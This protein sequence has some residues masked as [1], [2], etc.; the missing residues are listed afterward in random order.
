MCMRMFFSEEIFMRRTIFHYF[1]KTQLILWGASLLLI[2]VC[3]V[4]FGGTGYLTLAASLIGATSLIFNAKGNPFGQLLSVVFSVLYGIISYSFH[5][6]GEMITYLGMTAPMALFSFVSWMRNPFCAGRAEV[7]V[8]HLRKKE[9]V[10]MLLVCAAVTWIFYYVLRAFHTANLGLSTLSV[11]TSFL[12][13][14]LTWRRSCFFA[15]A[16]AANDIILILLW[17][18]ASFTDPAYRSVIV[19]FILFL[20]N[21]LYGF[22]CWRRMQKRQSGSADR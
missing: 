8:H 19:C 14:F 3:F 6:Y 7:R 22:F 2:S 11:S 15:L 17:I 18:L 5:Y 10:L 9:V 13:V 16:Y 21:D 4:L 1:S 12:A 20:V